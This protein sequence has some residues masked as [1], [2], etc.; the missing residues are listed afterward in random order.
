MESHEN[1]PGAHI[2]GFGGGRRL[3]CCRLLDGAAAHGGQ[4]FKQMRAGRIESFVLSV[5]FAGDA[6]DQALH[7]VTAFEQ[8]SRELAAEF[9]LLRADTVQHTF[10]YVSEADDGVQPEQSGRTLDGVGSA[11]NRIDRLRSEEHTSEL[12]SRFDLV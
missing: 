12:Q 1:S 8:D 7:V 5:A 10:D 9:E 4:T 3:R 2:F 6:V 11:K